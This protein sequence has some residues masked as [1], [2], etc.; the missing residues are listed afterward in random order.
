M[1]KK[2]LGA[3][4]SAQ[5]K[6][7][8]SVDEMRRRAQHRLIGA[9]VLVA[10]GVVGFPLV[11]DTNP[12]PLDVDMPIVIPNPNAVPALALP[13][14]AT[15]AQ[16]DGAAPVTAAPAESVEPNPAAGVPLVAPSQPAPAQ[17]QAPAPAQQTPEPVKETASDARWVVQVG[18]FTD[19]ASVRR[20]RQRLERAG[21]KTYTQII[22]RNG[23]RLTRVRLGPFDQQAKADAAAARARGLGLDVELLRL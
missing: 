9:V 6:P 17:V 18:S 11:F 14:A 1:L 3:K 4:Q 2:W 19:A 20:V 5:A 8:E 21:L 13:P 22:R 10:L 15:E 7:E 12:R 23:K 16:T